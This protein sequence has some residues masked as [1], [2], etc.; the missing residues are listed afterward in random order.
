[1]EKI[2]LSIIV[3][4]YNAGAFLRPCL[5]SIIAQTLPNIE[6]VL[7]DDGSNDGSSEIV[8]EYAQKYPFMKVVKNE[9][10]NGVKGARACGLRHVSG[11]YVGWVDDDDIVEPRMFEILYSSAIENDA[12]L[13]YCNYDFFPDR[14]SK[15]SRWVQPYKGIRNW[16]FLEHNTVPWNTITSSRL[17]KEVDYAQLMEEVSE[18]AKLA[19]L[20]RARKIIYIDK[21]LYHYRVGHASTSRGSLKGKVAYYQQGVE[22]TKKI[23][24]RILKGSGYEEELEEYFDYRLIYKYLLV[25]LVAAYNRDKGA[26]NDAVNNLKNL[27]YQNNKY[28]KVVLNK[29]YGSI[30]AL[31][32]S[33]LIPSN[34]YFASIVS[35]CL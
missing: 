26:Y 9:N 22:S 10:K 24:N 6:V 33:R 19:L 15:R 21:E 11:E 27:N 13:V 23:K 1:M 29:H 12:D 32:L 28:T 34:Y 35:Q 8:F 25:A 30:K 31:V 18:Y 5:D 7:V 17:L 14:N 2:K 3:P 16:E 4:V 20:L